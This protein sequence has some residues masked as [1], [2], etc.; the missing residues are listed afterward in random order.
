MKKINYTLFLIVRLMF[1]TNL[2]F[3]NTMENLKPDKP[4][5]SSDVMLDVVDGAIQVKLDWLE[6][7]G[8]FALT[9]L[10]WGP[11]TQ[12]GNVNLWVN[13][14][15][16]SRNFLTLCEMPDRRQMLV[17]YSFQPTI[18]SSDGNVQ[19]RELQPWEIVDTN[20]FQNSAYYKEFGTNSIEFKFFANGRWEGDRKNNNQNWRCVFSPPK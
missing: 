17:I 9:V 6:R 10:Y 16:V 19:I 13:F 2:L 15:G 7:P 20:L 3:G 12:E 11:L 18:K 14:N 8:E 4:I 5:S 1:I